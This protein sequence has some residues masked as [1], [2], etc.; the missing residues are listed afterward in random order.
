MTPF[1]IINIV[2]F[3]VERFVYSKTFILMSLVFPFLLCSYLYLNYSSKNHPYTLYV[4]NTTE[5]PFHFN[6]S[7]LISYVNIEKNRKI[8]CMLE[9]DREGDGILHITYSGKEKKLH[10]ELL[11]KHELQAEEFEMIKNHINN[12]YGNYLY[13]DSLTTIINETEKQY[14]FEYA[15]YYD[16]MHRN[17]DNHQHKESSISL[18]AALII[19]F[20][21]FQFSSNIMKSISIEKHNKIAEILLSSIQAEEII[22]G[23]IIAGFIL[24]LLQMIIWSIIIGTIFIIFSKTSAAFNAQIVLLFQNLSFLSTKE[25]ALYSMVFVF[26]LT[27][28]FLMYSSLFSII[29]AISNINTNTQQFS[30]I[31]TL[32][33]VISMTYII[34]N[35]GKTDK[36]TY[37]FSY[38]PL[39]SPIALITR[40]PYNINIY[41]ILTSMIILYLCIW[42]FMRLSASLYRHGIIADKE[43]ITVKTILSWLKL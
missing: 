15:S 16:T 22:T 29:G 28:G 33:L 34:S 3:E 17:K 6:N 1:K 38:F 26:S 21:I 7:E 20:I 8:E 36:W 11:Y 9:D 12:S 41:S 30:F 25:I 5:I 32:P 24:A 27:G 13:N 14:S 4:Q 39:T 43:K 23:K 10:I 31:L 42:G 2:K 35:M 19:Y 37:F 40:L 18:I